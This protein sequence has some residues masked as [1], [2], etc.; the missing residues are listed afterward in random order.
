[1]YITFVLFVNDFDLMA[2]N[3]ANQYGK[4][5]LKK[6]TPLNISIKLKIQIINS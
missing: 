3:M 6:E 5:H 1:M 4:K 2:H